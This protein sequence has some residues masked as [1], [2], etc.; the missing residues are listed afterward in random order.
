[1]QTPIE[2]EI[3]QF[4]EQWGLDNDVVAA[5][6][7]AAPVAQREVMGNFQP[8]TNTYNVRHLFTASLR[9][10]ASRHAREASI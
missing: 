8:K 6:I 2:Q 9:S 4:S 3:S 10:R 5:L 1:M 7:G